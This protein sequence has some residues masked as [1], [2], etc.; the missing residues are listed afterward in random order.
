MRYY[1]CSYGRY[2][3]T[4][5]LKV[6]IAQEADPDEKEIKISSYFYDKNEQSVVIRFDHSFESFDLSELKYYTKTESAYTS[7]KP[8]EAEIIGD[9]SIWMRF[10]LTDN[11][12]D[13]VIEIDC[14]NQSII[15]N[16]IDG[17][18][19]RF[20]NLPIVISGVSYYNSKDEAKIKDL[21]NLLKI[22]SYV[23]L[24]IL[25]FANHRMFLFFIRMI[26]KLSYFYFLNINFP[27]NAIIN[28]KSVGD[29]ILLSVPNLLKRTVSL[30]CSLDDLI[31]SRGIDCYT[32]NNVGSLY[33]WIIAAGAFKLIVYISNIIAYRGDAKDTGIRSII[34]R[35][36][37][38]VGIDWFIGLLY[39]IQINLIVGTV[40]VFI[41]A[42][43]PKEA[44]V[45][46]FQNMLELI[47]CILF[48]L[49]YIL[50]AA[51]VGYCGFKRYKGIEVKLEK[52][53]D[54]EFEYVELTQEE[55]DAAK[56]SILLS[57]VDPSKT[58]HGSVFLIFSILKHL[59]IP[60]ML[61]FN[62]NHP[63]TQC[64]T[65]LL[66]SAV[67]FLFLMY[68]KPL[69]I[70]DHYMHAFDETVMFCGAILCTLYQ[71]N[72]KYY[73][74]QE[75]FNVHGLVLMLILFVG[76]GGVVFIAIIQVFT[77][78]MNA[79]IAIYKDI[80]GRPLHSKIATASHTNGIV[81]FNRMGHVEDAKGNNSENNSLS[82]SD[83]LRKR[84]K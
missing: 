74:E 5:L 33:L 53:D 56:G 82:N 62:I 71:I 70:Q 7:I 39:V 75:R 8:K 80:K 15:K 49:I 22:L 24:I 52:E 69:N 34:N 72:G 32:S 26:Q 11:M 84:T 28:L 9:D 37:K 55:I 60:P 38:Y 47:F 48:Y 41:V 4:N 2:T 20:K 1:F 73:T 21:S 29:N 27:M 67:T 14:D 30:D 78:L 6:A 35:L 44:G 46:S 43:D 18:N 45:S 79:G 40:P 63:L 64:Y 3:K 77:T 12:N 36:N 51:Y 66:S 50:I 16:T 42:K 10:A 19:Y 25:L 54:P 17:D 13:G 83:N 57:P 31:M 59:V 61:I 68:Y 58:I 65:L 76:I 23:T 81:N